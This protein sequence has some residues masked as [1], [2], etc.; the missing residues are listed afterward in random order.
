MFSF[1][2]NLSLWKKI[3]ILTI[4]GVV[5]GV[6]VFAALGMKAVNEATDGMLQER[7][8]I[9]HLVAD[10]VDEALTRAQNEM[11]DSVAQIETEGNL[12]N[13]SSAM[14]DLEGEYARLSI[15]TSGIFLLNGQ[16]AVLASRPASPASS[17]MDPSLLPDITQAVT[18]DKPLVSRMVPV[19]GNSTP[20]V[21]LLSPVHLKATSSLYVMAV[22]VDLAQSSIGVFVRPVTLGQTGYVELVDQSGV[23]ITR[24]TP[25][26]ALVPFERSDH[27]G[28]FVT[29][30]DAGKPTRG[31]CHNCH[32][33]DNT[34][35]SR[36][37]LAFVPLSTTHWGVV[38]R[39][40]EAEALAPANN[41]RQ[42]ILLFGA[43]LAAAAFL[44]GF[45]L[46]R[47]IGGRIRSLTV[48][49][50][51]IAGGDLASP[52]AALGRDEVGE[53]AASF[54][55]MRS[56][57]KDSYGNLEQRTRELASLLSVSEVVASSQ[58]LPALLDGV[59]NK[60]SEVIPGAR[61]A[62]LLIS[63]PDGKNLAV[64]STSGFPAG[65][66]APKLLHLDGEFQGLAG[67][68][69]QVL[70]D[71]EVCSRLVSAFTSGAPLEVGTVACARVVRQGQCQ[72]VLLVFKTLPAVRFSDSD[73]RLLQAIADDIS[74]AL[75][76]D[77]LARDAARARALYEADKLRSQFIS[78]VTHELRTPLTIIK[79]Y[80]TSLLREN[81][82]WDKNTQ[83]EFLRNIDE[84]TDEL[85]ELIDKIL[86]SAKLEAGALRLEK[87]PLLIPR[88]A[89]KIIQDNVHRSKRH[90]FVPRFDPS[91]PVIE[92][93]PR[94][95]EQVLRNLVENAVKYSPLGGEI[96]LSGQAEGNEIIIGVHDQG[97]GI[98]P[99]D[100]EKVFERF[101][102]VASVD[103]RGVSGSGLGLSIC[104]GHVRAHGG[105]I[106]VESTLGKGSTFYF[107]L[108]LNQA[109][110]IEK[111]LAGAGTGTGL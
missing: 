80:A 15:R 2:I 4:L 14:A 62:A 77:R 23:V 46:V 20:A 21:F 58:E 82:A 73:R 29:L 51:K 31:V 99:E 12:D 104:K 45:I 48:A 43:L 44:I 17:S 47:N 27:S 97:I 53:L 30:I 25:G 74:I 105:R 9:A 36:D 107:S 66:A 95:I 65:C 22:A 101:F 11:S 94:C 90:R 8:T 59:V 106:W 32:E 81:V 57:L 13:L 34:V 68:D 3:I 55:E 96:C 91:F 70:V 67:E 76:R 28:R 102:R 52:V 54:D 88:L 71:R 26:P 1:L 98:A 83:Q 84:K 5:V 40:S 85:R 100:Q 72:G 75:E 41:L 86:Q 33:A 7:L 16:G 35:V 24:T 38:V 49:S 56:K 6:G 89:R 108:P 42:N 79:G 64:Q 61:A 110:E 93:D 50:R 103:T 39:Q 60:A 10:Y 18:V 37:V 63:S 111:D 87:E 69:W 109:E 92:A 19:P 78:S